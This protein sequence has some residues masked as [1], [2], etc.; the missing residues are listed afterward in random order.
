M[1]YGRFSSSSLGFWE[2]VL[3]R[4]AATLKHMTLQRKCFAAFKMLARRTEIYRKSYTDDQMFFMDSGVATHI[5]DRVSPALCRPAIASS[6]PIV[7][8]R[9]FM[10]EF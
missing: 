10:P 7:Q 4:F 9:S 2:D 5:S 1:A 8:S 3:A 6:I